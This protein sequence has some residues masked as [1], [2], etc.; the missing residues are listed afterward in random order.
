[1]LVA[2]VAGGAITAT[3]AMLSSR[4]GGA[5]GSSEM[6]TFWRSW[7]LADA[8]GSLVIIPL[9]L[10]WAQPHALT[11]WGRSAWEGVLVIGAVV[12]LSAIA[13]SA[14]LPLTY[15]VFPALI[16]A[17]LRF[18]QR[19]ATLAVVVAAVTA[20]GIS[21]NEV[22]VF[23]TQSITDSALATQLYIA[24]AALTTLC[25]AAIVSER[26]RGVRELDESRARA[27]AA[28]AQERRRLEAELH[29]RAQNRLVGLQIRLSLAQDRAQAIAPEI[30][31]TLAGLV[32]EAESLGDELQRIA[33]GD[34]PPLLATRGLVEALRAEGALRGVAVE[35]AAGDIGASAADI[36][37]AVFLCCLESIL[38]AAEHAGRDAGVTVRLRRD[39]GELA[40][41]VRDTGPGFD[42]RG[43]P[44]GGSLTGVRDRIEAVGGRVEISSAP[45]RGATVSGAVPWPPQT[46]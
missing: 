28:G 7:F 26:E 22:G 15:M 4:A 17:A 11:W 37:K 46:A 39:G 12:A 2:I 3:V 21:A 36:E 42:A 33:H 31:G 35:I 30:A 8:S 18:G 40:F 23:V 43:T 13:M 41:S 25:L 38:N 45:G 44:P 9:A 10:A 27:A 34:S 6:A 19:G 32:G 1:M 16:W 20:V 24:V 5:V 29:D 14:E